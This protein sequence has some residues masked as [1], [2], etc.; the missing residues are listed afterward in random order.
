MI[1]RV[2]QLYYWVPA[3][4]SACKAS[5]IGSVCTP[6]WFHASP[7]L[8]LWSQPCRL[9]TPPPTLPPIPVPLPQAEASRLPWLPIPI[10]LCLGVFLP[11]DQLSPGPHNSAYRHFL[12]EPLHMELTVLFMHVK[13]C[14]CLVDCSL[15]EILNP[16]PLDSWNWQSIGNLLGWSDK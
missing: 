11:P 10:P 1:S 5:P 15:W 14:S 4:W 7:Y 16:F 3:L 12:H 8:D 9:Q 6:H 2:I 13:S